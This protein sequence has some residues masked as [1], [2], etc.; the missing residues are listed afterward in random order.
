MDKTLI[1]SDHLS[2]NTLAGQVAMVTGAGRGI[3]FETARALAALGATVIIA[4]ID[5]E[6]GHSAANRIQSEL[7]DGKAQFIHTDVSD[8]NSVRDLATKLS[9]AYSTVDIIINNA[10]VTPVGMHAW[11][12][13]VSDWDYSYQINLRGPVLLAQA[14]L[15]KMVMQ[16]RGVFVFVSS[17]GAA[18]FMGPYEVMKTA[19][20]ELATTLAAE[21]EESNVITFTIGPGIVRTPGALAAIEKLAPLYGKTVES[22]FAMNKA[23]E[24]SEEEAGAGFAAAV[25]LAPQFRGQEISSVQALIAAGIDIAAAKLEPTTIGKIS[26]WSEAA[27]LCRKIRQT[28]A[29]QAEGW[30]ERNLFERQWVIRDFK[31]NAGMPVDQWLADLDRL[32]QSLDAGEMDGVTAVQ[33]PLPRLASYYAHLQDLAKGYEK[34]PDKLAEYLRIVQSWQDDVEHLVMLLGNEIG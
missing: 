4:E 23:H 11:E 33:L 5:D 29:E 31:K 20:V 7:G 6:N 18:P 1:L 13:A 34:D 16:N 8:E 17:S 2:Q 24:L 28:L 19:Q 14:F 9:K 15:P 26:D 27:Q 25:A 21:L 12:T 22:F 30:Q 32:A 10:T 3:G